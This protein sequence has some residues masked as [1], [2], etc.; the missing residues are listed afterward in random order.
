MLTVP[1]YRFQEGMTELPDKPWL[2][3]T[4]AARLLKI[5]R[6]TIY[7]WIEAGEVE[8][9]GCKYFQKVSKVSLE[10]K[11]QLGPQWRTS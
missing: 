6:S 11:M 8:V 4:E 5:H 10:K 3:V 7:R 9:C 2:F 1:C